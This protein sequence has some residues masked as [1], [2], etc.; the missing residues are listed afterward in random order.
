MYMMG[1]YRLPRLSTH[2]EAKEFCTVSKHTSATNKGGREGERR[3]RRERRERER[4]GERGREREGEERWKERERR[5]GRRGRGEGE[6]EGEGD[7]EGGICCNSAFC[8]SHPK[9][10]LEGVAPLK[11]M[12]VAIC[13]PLLIGCHA[14]ADHLW[15]MMSC[16]ISTAHP[17]PHTCMYIITKYTYL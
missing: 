8:S 3:E 1:T 2:R 4:E 12:S 14:L 9:V 13:I 17:Q 15:R 16:D 11:Q 7:R 10:S 6:G 5:G